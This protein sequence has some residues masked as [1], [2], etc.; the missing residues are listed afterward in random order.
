VPTTWDDLLPAVP[1][2]QHDQDAAAVAQAITRSCG[3][4][5]APG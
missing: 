2:R 5:P 3:G 4:Q 1:A